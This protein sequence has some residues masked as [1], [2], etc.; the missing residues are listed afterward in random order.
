MCIEYKLYKF[1]KRLRLKNRN[2]TVFS[3]NCNGAY[4]LHDLGCPFNSPTVDLYFLPDHFLKF[5][6]D[7][8]RYLNSE[9][10][11]THVEGIT[12]PVGKIEDVLLFFMHYHSFDEAK[13]TWERRSKRVN[14]NNVYIVMT[15]KDKCSYENIKQFDELPYKNKVIFT[16]KPYPEFNS[17]IYIPGFESQGEVGILS[18][19]KPQLLKRRWLDD[20]DYVS[21]F[22]KN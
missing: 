4:M 8:M 14:M 17:V 21:F 12:Y 10:I 13:I 18:D 2:M 15:D 1:V 16:H 3:S 7:P 22:N 5:V 6:N 19:W 9:L 11:E 20:Y